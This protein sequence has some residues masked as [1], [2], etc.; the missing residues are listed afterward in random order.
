MLDPGAAQGDNRL[1]A[2]VRIPQPLRTIAKEA[3]M[4]ETPTPLADGAPRF[5]T[6]EPVDLRTCWAD[7]ARDFTPW[8][9][10]HEGLTLLG[11]TLSMELQVEGLEVPVGPYNA[12]ILAR[13]LASNALVIVENQLEK[14]NHDHFGKILTYAAVLGR[15]DNGWA[16][17]VAGII[18]AGA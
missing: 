17:G 16:S 5:A 9:A 7:E 13:D 8:L 3:L 15:V 11:G 1:M 14:T 4:A 2:S 10:T 6:I 12:D 18:A